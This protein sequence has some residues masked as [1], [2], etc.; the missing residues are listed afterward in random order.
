MSIIEFIVNRLIRLIF[1]CVCSYFFLSSLFS[2][3]SNLNILVLP[4]EKILLLLT[5]S[6]LT[7]AISFLIF[8]LLV[9]YFWLG[10][11]FLFQF[12]DI[13]LISK[14]NST[15][16]NNFL[17]NW[18]LANKIKLSWYQRATSISVFVLAIFVFIAFI[19]FNEETEISKGIGG[20]EKPVDFDFNCPS[21]WTYFTHQVSNSF[22]YFCKET[23]V[24]GV[25]FIKNTILSDVEITKI[26]EDDMEIQNLKGTVN[27]EILFKTINGKKYIYYN[28]KSNNYSL[29][30]GFVICNNKTL[31]VLSVYATIDQLN[32]LQIILNSVDCKE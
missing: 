20:L 16:S 30:Q 13:K 26:L 14:I 25:R 15:K 4:L 21:D 32:E 9:Y 6:G 11:V 17:V 1:T 8:Y 12:I 7:I 19:S 31:D 10:Y 23:N 22:G 5:I 2:S 24:V 28:A 29:E 3:W 27:R 18:I